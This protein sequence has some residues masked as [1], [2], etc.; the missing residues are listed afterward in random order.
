M[1]DYASL[2][3]LIREVLAQESPLFP[4]VIYERVRGQASEEA[5]DI[6][7]AELSSGGRIRWSDRGG[8]ELRH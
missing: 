3:L 2:S 7:L 8:W 6:Q 1:S 4:N 5:C